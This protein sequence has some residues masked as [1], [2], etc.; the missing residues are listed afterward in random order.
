[1]PTIPKDYSAQNVL[2]TPNTIYM[3]KALVSYPVLA[4]LLLLQFAVQLA[5]IALVSN[6]SSLALYLA[7]YLG[8]GQLV[9]AL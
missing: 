7:I 4:K 6:C 1:L 5:G 2:N 3:P 9:S 8:P